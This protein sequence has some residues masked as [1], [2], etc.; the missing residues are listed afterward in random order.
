MEVPRALAA[1]RPLDHCLGA[2]GDVSRETVQA[3]PAACTVSGARIWV[4]KKPPDKD[5]GE[6]GYYQAAAAA[7]ALSG[8]LHMQCLVGYWLQA[9]GSSGWQLRQLLPSPM[10]A[11]CCPPGCARRSGRGR[12]TAGQSARRRQIQHADSMSLVSMCL[13]LRDTYNNQL[14]S[15]SSAE[16]CPTAW[17][18]RHRDAAST[19]AWQQAIPHKHVLC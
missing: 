4:L 10:H 8:A 9:H 16:G 19:T 12:P 2:V 11:C 14:L 6:C 3:M 17:I 13:L 7:D 18:Q 5:G 15:C 1:A